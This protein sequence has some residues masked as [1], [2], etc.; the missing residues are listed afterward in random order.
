MYNRY[1]RNDNGTAPHPGG[2]S[3]SPSLRTRNARSPRIQIH[4]IRPMAVLP[5]RPDQADIKAGPI[6]RFT[7]RLRQ[8][9][10][11]ALLRQAE[12][13]SA[14]H[15]GSA[16]SGP[17][18]WQGTCCFDPAVFLVP[19]GCRR[20][21]AGG[22]GT[23]ASD[24]LKKSGA[25]TLPLFHF[26]PA[27]PRSRPAGCRPMMGSSS[28][29]TGLPHPVDSLTVQLLFPAATSSPVVHADPIPQDIAIRIR[30]SLPHKCSSRRRVCR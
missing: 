7:R 14:A 29:S 28:R 5:G 21:S 6:R 11:A 9:S 20:R 16:A 1:V 30:S 2:I 17:Y 23:A 13:F 26:Q 27:S 8:G 24:S 18:G 15:F 22:P 10:P 25:C 3:R 4:P 12:Q 19:G